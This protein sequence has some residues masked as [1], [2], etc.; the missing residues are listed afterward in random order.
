M[1]SAAIPIATSALGGIFSGIGASKPRT[2]TSTSES[3]S[4]QEG[5]LDNKQSKVMKAMFQQILAALKLGP[6]VAQSDR[7]TARSQ[8]NQNFDTGAAGLEA[9]LAARGMSGG[10]KTGTGLRDLGLDRLKAQQSSEAIL[11]DQATQKFLQMLGIGQSFITPRTINTTSSGTQTGTASGTP[12]Q[13]SV[14]GGVSDL[15]SFLYLQ[16]ILGGAGG[17]AFNAAGTGNSL[18]GGYACRIAMELWGANDY[19]VK[20]LREWLLKQAEQSWQWAIGVGIYKQTGR[21]V[22]RLIRA[23]ILRG[24]FERLFGNLVVRAMNT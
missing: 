7:N 12:W 11:R 15:G 21:A 8:I 22:A 3:R 19:R 6:N 24:S 13:S 1:P 9:N 20:I 16:K 17:G 5:V 10:G 18:G 4:T 23:G 14:G 2:S